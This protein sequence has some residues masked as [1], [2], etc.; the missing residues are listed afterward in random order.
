MTRQPV[1][2]SERGIPDSLLVGLL[3]FLLGLTVLV[4]TATG[5]AAWSAHGTWPETVTFGRTPSA[6]RS[7]LAQPH[8]IA[9]AWPDTAPTA[10]AGYGLVWGIFIGQLMVLFVLT[11]FGMGVLARV[12]ARRA[13][14][15]HKTAS[16]AQKATEV[17]GDDTLPPHTTLTGAPTGPQPPWPVAQGDVED[18]QL[19]SVPAQR[20]SHAPVVTPPHPVPQAQPDPQGSPYV[21]TTR[22]PLQYGGPS[23]RRAAALRR[24]AE[25]EGA[26]L[27]VTSSPALWA[28]TKDARAKLGPVLV[29]DPSHLCDTPDRL[30][31]SPTRGCADQ[32]TAGAR[33][34]AL[35]APVRPQSRL[36]SAVA[37]TAH[38]LLRCWLHAADLD[39]RPFKHVHRWAQ[40]TNAHDPVRILRT[41][42]LAAPGLAG[43]LESALSGHP[44][45]RDIAQQ[46]IGRVLACLSSVHIRDSCTPQRSDALRLESFIA[47]GGSLYVVGESLEDPRSNPGAMPL[48]TAIAANVVEHGRRMAVR[49]SH[50]RLDPP[51]SLILEDVAAV[52]PVPQLP[53]L[54]E[55]RDAELPV[56]ALCR[57][58]EQFRARWPQADLHV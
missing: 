26:A 58:Q 20:P 8:D 4:W 21:T 36:D 30:R 56:L 52:A 42:S 44:E 34:G 40:G 9:A 46:L 13:R 43:E 5:L 29:Y 27:I 11:V 3:A 2:R 53:R 54:L 47:E 49:S 48:L 45:R 37:D 14:I 12:K 15:R 10:L 17:S 31:W 38:T 39:E 57:S 23:Q 22:S 1:E 32:V 18:R 7:L 16:A 33:A 19:D 55:T 6:V 25:A 41:H 50:G 28:D 35:L 51:L 24:I